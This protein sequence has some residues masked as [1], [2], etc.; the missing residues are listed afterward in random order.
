MG[1]TFHPR[2][3]NGPFDDS[4]LFVSFRYKRR[5]LLF[6]LGTIDRLGLREIHK[7]TDVFVSH[8]HID[9]FIGFDHLLR[10]SLNKEDELRIY[11][12]KG[13]I[14]NVQGKLAGY[15]WN[16]IE[17]YPLRIA[18][19]EIHS[20]RHEKAYFF[21]ANKFRRE[22]E[23]AVPFT[24]TLVEEP[25]FFIEARILDHSIPCLAFALKEKKRLNVRRERLQSM[26]LKSGPWLDDLKRML[27][28]AAPPAT[29]W[30][31]PGGDGNKKWSLTLQQWREHL[32]RETEGQVIVYVVDCLF[33]PDNADRILSLAEGADLFYCEAAFSKEDE[34]RAKSRYHLTANQAGTLARM[35]RVK[36][37]VPFHFSLVYEAES[38]RLFEE[39]MQAFSGA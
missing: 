2:L 19:H 21:A 1:N 35:A 38:N 32:I 25:S 34:E 29:R 33:S 10:C 22:E 37:F 8:T 3:V 15:T 17:N 16:L 23:Q 6:D 13:I 9:H 36:S 28:E 11:G 24:G 5:A 12:P 30:E 20:D 4:A 39:A 27:R 26:G 31:A 18:V 7:L 14:D